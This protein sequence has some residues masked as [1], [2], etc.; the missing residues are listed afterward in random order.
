MIELKSISGS[1]F[2][3]EVKDVSFRLPNGKTYGV[4]STHYADAVCLLALLSGARTPTGGSVLAGGFDL[5]REA[6]E[7][8][9]SITYLSANLLPDNELTPI[10][11]LMTVADIR[12]LPYD[13][14][15]RHAHELLEL[16][17]LSGKKETLISNLSYSEKRILCLLQL[18]LGK[19]EFLVLTS[20]FSG[21]IPKDV[22]KMRD[23]I[24]YLGDTYT[25]FICTPSP[26]ELCDM[27]D[28]ILVLEDSTLKTIAPANDEALAKELSAPA[29]EIVSQPESNTPKSNREKALWKLLMQKSGE[30]EVLDSEEKEDEN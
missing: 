23:L 21:L 12:E 20:P 15:L 4:F 30:C 22:Q 27:C 18:L 8:R 11:Y 6:K 29:A 28:E 7:A 25:I 10:E 14:T 19:P 24:H 1:C 16:A 2:S 9:R 13:K 3:G 26:K 17:D 5:H